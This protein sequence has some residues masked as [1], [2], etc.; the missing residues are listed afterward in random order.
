MKYELATDIAARIERVW[1]LLIDVEDW[2]NR[3]RAFRKVTLVTPGS[4]GPGSVAQVTQPGLPTARWAVS[5]WDV[6]TRFD[7]ESQAPGV[8]TV[9]RHTLARIDDEHTRLTLA[10]EQT[11]GLS[12]LA[13]LTFG[14]RTRAYVQLEADGLKKLAEG[15][16]AV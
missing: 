4:L 3:S 6:G 14:R 13:S 8:H 12:D 5:R 16:P 11:G 15:R 9:G 2:P 1:S 10:I 7:W